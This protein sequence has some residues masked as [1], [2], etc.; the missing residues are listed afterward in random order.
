MLIGIHL[1][2]RCELRLLRVQLGERITERVGAGAL[3]DARNEQRGF[4]WHSSGFGAGDDLLECLAVVPRI[5]V[6]DLLIEEAFQCWVAGHLHAGGYGTTLRR[7]RYRVNAKIFQ[8]FFRI[9][10]RPLG[11]SKL[12]PQY[13]RELNDIP[14]FQLA[15]NIDVFL[16]PGVESQLRQLRIFT[17]ET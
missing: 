14:L 9:V 16:Q 6:L 7:E 5:V 3:G 12:S 17:A 4:P 8:R 1:P 10:E 2:L 15:G 13:V 11:V